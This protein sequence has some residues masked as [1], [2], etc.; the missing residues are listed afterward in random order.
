MAL[1]PYVSLEF[2][3]NH[4]HLLPSGLDSDNP[5]V[6]FHIVCQGTVFVSRRIREH[7]VGDLDSVKN[8]GNAER[9]VFSSAA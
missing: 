1:V 6:Y 5:L 7:I 3:P 4:Q 2:Q 9:M 8:Q